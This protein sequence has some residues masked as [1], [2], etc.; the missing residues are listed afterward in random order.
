MRFPRAAL[1]SGTRLTQRA[2]DVIRGA[3]VFVLLQHERLPLTR[4]HSERFSHALL[5]CHLSGD[6][7]R[8]TSFQLFGHTPRCDLIE[9][10]VGHASFAL[11]P[12][13]PLAERP[14][15]GLGLR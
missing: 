2:L 5:L 11:N 10:L 6:V 14:S 7:L 1:E 3:G 13:S 15:V 8:P 9:D 4:Q 12:L